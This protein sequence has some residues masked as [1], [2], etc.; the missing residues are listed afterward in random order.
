MMRRMRGKNWRVPLVAVCQFL[1]LQSALGQQVGGQRGL[2]IVTVEGEGAKNVVQQI[3]PKPLIVRV[4]DANN[5]PVPG[6]TVV[7][8]AP[9]GGPSG[10]FSNDS[11]TMRVITGQDGLAAAGMFHPNA[12]TGPYQ[13]RVSAQLEA[14][15]ATAVIS[16]INATERKGHGKLFTVLIVAG[17]AA[18]AA[19]AYRKKNGSNA[20]DTPTIT[21]GGAAVGAPK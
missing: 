13:I 17:A 15:T 8:T 3:A 11:R 14:E 6:A 9:D 1:V 7:F 2:K 12:T 21:F 16:Q 19:L 4:E 10:E 18:G 20:S 5:R